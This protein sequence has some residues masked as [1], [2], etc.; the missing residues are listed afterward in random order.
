MLS[1]LALCSFA[2]AMVAPTATGMKHGHLGDGLLRASIEA[3]PTLPFYAVHF[4]PQPP[5]PDW[6]VGAVSSVAVAANGRLY[7]VQRGKQA[8]PV[9]AVDG[10]GNVV[11]AW[12]AGDFGIPHTVRLDRRGNVWTIDAESSTAL[13]FSPDGKTLLKIG[14]GGQPQNGSPFNGATDI[15]F[16]PNGH[17][18]ITDGYGNARILEYSEDG[19]SLRQ[20]GHRGSGP[21]D[22]NLPHS[23][24]IDGQGTI[25]VADRE[26]GRIE[27][28][29]LNGKY[30]R[31][32][33]HL[34][35]IY[36]IQLFGNA[37][38]ATMEPFDQDPGS[39]NGWLVKL[40]RGTGKI[41]G[42]LDLSE[43]RTGHSLA[44]TPAG[45]PIVTAGD[46][47]LWF[48]SAKP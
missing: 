40:D 36:S 29:A 34:G 37:I 16:A 10:T 20:W 13:E 30:L 24:Q 28:F 15:A 31:Q 1:R 14:V 48:K 5:G 45:E 9:V 12:G 23:I 41:I 3:S 11:G 4:A 42:H 6:Q 47:L 33:P 39:G 18:F 22:F 7:I 2:V 25:Y 38:W 26:N 35:R 19:K 17:I 32:I 8:P 43:P 44:I 46:E 27:E 21:G